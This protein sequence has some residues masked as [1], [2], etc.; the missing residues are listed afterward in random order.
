M[1]GRRQFLHFT[2]KN[3]FLITAGNQLLPLLSQ[4][5]S[6]PATSKVALRFAIASDGHYG[7]ENTEYE[8]R[9]DLVIRALNTEYKGRGIDFTFV[10][11]DLFHNDPRHFEP[12]K[13]KWDGLR[14][15]WHASHGNHDMV[16]EAA[17]KQM[18]GQDWYYGFEQGPCG[19]VVLN[20]ADAAGEYTCPELEKTKVLLE[21]HAHHPF[22]FVFMHITP[23][24]WTSAGIHCPELVDL[25]N[26]QP[27]LKAVFHGHDHDQEGAWMKEGISY[28]FDAH[29]AGNWGLPYTGYRIV[30]VMKD[31]SILTYQM[32]A[33]T[34]K[35]VNRYELGLP[36]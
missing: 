16:G 24:K 29:V 34:G 36:K 8:A 11:G 30:E 32:N 10:N 6:L 25:F 1:Y 7:Q 5:G 21:Q 33:G 19:F 35:E 26:R 13:K 15:P 27:N 17:W 28:L 22:L 3:A 18:T 23:R 31:G 9:H 2:L 4:T 14:M 12:V 20:T